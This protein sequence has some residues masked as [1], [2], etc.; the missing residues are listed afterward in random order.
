MNNPED[1]D[2]IGTSQGEV[3]IHRPRTEARVKLSP[4]LARGGLAHLARAGAAQVYLVLDEIRGTHDATVLNMHLRLPEDAAS[5]RRE[6]FAAGSVGLY[7]LRR[8]SA[9]QGLQFTLDVTAFFAG[10]DPSSPSLTDDRDEVLVSILLHRE[11]PASDPVVI[12]RILLLCRRER[13]QRP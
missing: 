5:G 2:L 6:E 13:A 8:A 11:L 7:G 3:V 10:L 12:G 4:G 9:Q 1:G